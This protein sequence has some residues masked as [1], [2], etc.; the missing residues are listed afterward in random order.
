MTLEEIWQE[1]QLYQGQ[2]TKKFDLSGIR[3]QFY[4]GAMEIPMIV[5]SPPVPFVL[6]E[7]KL[8]EFSDVIAPCGLELDCVEE[9][10][11]YKINR[12]ADGQY[13]GRITPNALKLHAVRAQELGWEHFN[14]IVSFHLNNFESSQELSSSL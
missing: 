8:S 4:M 3:T 7:N 1:L 9:G 2:G 13:L 5:F 10:N 12:S 14:I 11:N 6:K